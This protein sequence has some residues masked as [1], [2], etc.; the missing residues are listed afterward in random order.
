ML[1]SRAAYAALM[2]VAAVI[3]SVLISR[4][5]RGLA[6]KSSDRW[7]IL[8]S[9][10][11]GAT[12]AAKLP[13]VL[14]SQPGG[15]LWTT[16]ISDGKTIL[17]GL[18]GGY[19][20]VEVG[21]WMLGVRTRTGDSFVVGIALAIA[22]GRVGCLMF[23]CCFGTPTDLPW[24]VC[25]VSADDGGT[26]PRHPTQIYETLF[27]TAFAI[28]AAYG[29]KRSWFAGNWM[30]IYLI[31]YCVYRFASEWIRPEAKL[32]AGLTFYQMSAIVIAVAMS[33]ILIK[34][35]FGQSA[36]NQEIVSSGMR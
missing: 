24:G 25:F 21:K 10:F 23:G 7:T 35:Y 8:A 33:G 12:F 19:L 32:L 1:D 22:I 2:I 6:I 29:I 3:A 14:F 11:V 18:A 30:P 36:G 4:Q 16:W 9:G 28:I 17:W 26:I 27:H 15:P 31:A 13:F 34:R 5:Q 20:G